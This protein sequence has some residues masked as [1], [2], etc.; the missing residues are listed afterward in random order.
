MIY[1]EIQEHMSAIQGLY[2]A[3]KDYTVQNLDLIGLLQ[4]QFSGTMALRDPPPAF[5]HS[6]AY[7]IIRV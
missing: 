1:S 6:L 7:P 3:E 4:L 2:T 5:C